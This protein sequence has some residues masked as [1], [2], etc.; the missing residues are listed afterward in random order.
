MTGQPTSSQFSQSC[1]I[2]AAPKPDESLTVRMASYALSCGMLVFVVTHRR[3]FTALRDG[4][5]RPP[6]GY[7]LTETSGR[8]LPWEW[9]WLVPVVVAASTAAWLTGIMSGRAAGG[10]RIALMVCG[11]LFTATASGVPL[12]Q[13]ARTSRA[14]ADAIAAAQAA[15][16]AMRV[17]LQDALDPLAA[18]LLQLATAKPRQKPLL[19]GE[20]IGLTVTTIAQV[21]QPG[22]AADLG[23]SGRLRVC[24][25]GLD[26]GP[27][28]ML[29][30]RAHAG[31]SGAPAVSF[32]QGTRAGQFLLRIA[33]DG[34]LTID[35]IGQLRVPVWWDD[36]HQYRTFAAGPVPGPG[37]EPA[38]LITLDALAPG[39]L[40]TLDLPLVRLLT[41]L[42]SLALQM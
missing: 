22:G 38:G 8:G 15:R 26:A 39:E 21:C 17:A 5:V 9:R 16:A 20:V 35:D 4:G 29:I 34:W 33:D 3:R 41:H 42:L 14:R 31:R 6:P 24:Y 1:C 32:G 7:T 11:A 2:R 40:A 18:L 27:P 25:F 28:R 23:T 30:P 36:D 19:R 13:Q 10:L 12:W 37:G